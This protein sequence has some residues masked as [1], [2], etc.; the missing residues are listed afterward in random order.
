MAGEIR[1]R[2]M[3]MLDNP[4]TYQASPGYRFALD[5]GTQAAQRAA[6]ASGN[7]GSGNALAAIAKY[8][9]GLASQDYGSSVDRL[10]RLYATEDAGDIARTRNA[11]DLTLGEGQLAATNT[12]NANDFTLGTGALDVSRQ[13]ANTTRDLG[14]GRLNLDAGL[15]YGQLGETTR[16]HDLDF[17]L[18]NTRAANDFTLGSQQNQNTAQ[19]NAWDYNLGS[20]AADTAGYNARTQRGTAQSQDR[21]RRDDSRRYWSP[22]V[23]PPNYGTGGY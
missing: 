10:G 14:F 6:A 9:Q 21:A 16:A 22:R 12:R 1:N 23:L 13:N 5:Q 20:R 18:G 8:A 4:G 15:G 11:N 7:R 19:R 17:T 2:L 3:A